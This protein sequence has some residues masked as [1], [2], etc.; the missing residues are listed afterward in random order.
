MEDVNTFSVKFWFC[1]Y[2]SRMTDELFPLGEKK[3]K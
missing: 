1:E 3:K 2:L